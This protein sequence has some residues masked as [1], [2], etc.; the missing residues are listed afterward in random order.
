MCERLTRKK[1]GL[2][3]LTLF[4]V[5]V[6]VVRLLFFCFAACSSERGET[7]GKKRRLDGAGW[8]SLCVCM[9]RLRESLL[10]LLL[11]VVQVYLRNRSGFTII[12]IILLCTKYNGDTSFLL[13]LL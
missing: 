12:T 2:R 7:K 1:K 10:K 3:V 6:V 4:V 9:F 13:I 8:L 11:R 5:V